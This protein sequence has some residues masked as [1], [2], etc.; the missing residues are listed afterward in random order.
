[1]RYRILGPLQVLDDEGLPVALGGRLDACSSPLFC[2]RPT[3]SSLRTGL[4]MPCRGEHPP[5]TAANGLQVNISKLRKRL[6]SS[7]DFRWAASRSH[8]A[9]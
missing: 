7:A 6:A 3:V 1:M 2:L 4:S 9:M 8:R 5:E